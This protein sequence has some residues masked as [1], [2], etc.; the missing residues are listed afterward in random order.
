MS[1]RGYH[2][3]ELYFDDC[4]VSQDQL[5]GEEGRHL[6]EQRRAP[7]PR[8]R[9][10]PVDRSRHHRRARRRQSSAMNYRA[11]ALSDLDAVMAHLRQQPEVDMQRLLV[12]GV[13][14]QYQQGGE[15]G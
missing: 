7:L 1:H 3:C 8:A 13:P 10:E 11:M 14:V 12:G 6:A 4:V 9:V 15:P 5:L 2:Q